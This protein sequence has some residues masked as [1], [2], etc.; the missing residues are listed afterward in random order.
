MSGRI[1]VGA[2]GL[3]GVAFV[4]GL[5]LGGMGPRAEVRRL[6]DEVFD[7]KR[8]RS[9]PRLGGPFGEMFTRAL[10]TKEPPPAAPAPDGEDPLKAALTAPPDE[11][12][13]LQPPEEPAEL[14]P[15]EGPESMEAAREAMIARS[16]QARA[17]LIE[18]AEPNDE[19]LA[20]IDEAIGRM[21]D[22]LKGLVARVAE[23]TRDGQEPDRRVSMRIAADGLDAFVQAE[24]EILSALTPD[25]LAAV[26]DEATD[27]T[28][29]IDVGVFDAFADVAED[30][31]RGGE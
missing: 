8:D 7:L 10:E 12:E 15:K 28:S 6:E 26:R 4:A 31:E 30:I 3:A 29:F 2:L 27:P 20:A 19:Q 9:G 14:D 22:R 24:D 25:Q 5:V 1:G 21:N 18:D 23:E 13:P 16:A 17:A 11:G